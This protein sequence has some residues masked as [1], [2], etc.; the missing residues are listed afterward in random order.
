MLHPTVR[1]VVWGA[2]AALVQ[3]L[4]LADLS[5]ACVAALAAGGLLAPKRLGILLKRTRW[6]IV[7]LVL[8]FALSTPGVYLLP[9]LGSL[10]PTEEGLRLGFEHLMRL[11]FLLATLA[12]LLQMTE[13]EGLVAGLHGLILPLSWLGL[14]RGRVA[15]RL[16][17]VMQYVEQSTPGRHWRAWL[18]GAN[19]EPVVGV[20]RLSRVRFSLVDYAVLV[21][22]TFGVIVFLGGAP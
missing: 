17:L 16:M 5:L 9:S 6:L 2:A 13:V 11:L 1:L 15:V 21:G 3:W 22:L 12:V 7:S 20:V 4:P 10:G 18:D 14:D 8:L 19:V